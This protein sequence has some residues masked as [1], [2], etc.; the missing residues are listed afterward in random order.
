M[1][2][3]MSARQCGG[4]CQVEVSLTILKMEDTIHHHQQTNRSDYR[5]RPAT[6]LYTF[7]HQNLRSEILPVTVLIL[8][9]CYISGV[10]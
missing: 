2:Q 4:L 3:I 9:D 6:N 1:Q 7:L 5:V 10:Y 8:I